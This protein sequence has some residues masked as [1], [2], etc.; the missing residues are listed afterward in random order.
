M[1]MMHANVGPTKPPCNGRSDIPPVNKSV[2]AIMFF[3]GCF[4]FESYLGTNQYRRHL[5]K[6]SSIG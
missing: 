6:F 5:D 4:K 1:A 3:N 2:L